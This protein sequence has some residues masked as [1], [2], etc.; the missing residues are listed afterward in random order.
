MRL[1]QICGVL[2]L[3]PIPTLTDVVAHKVQLMRTATAY[4]CLIRWYGLPAWG[5][6]IVQRTFDNLIVLLPSIISN[7]EIACAGSI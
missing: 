1:A 2:S 6:R 7:K 4:A 3:E 5:A